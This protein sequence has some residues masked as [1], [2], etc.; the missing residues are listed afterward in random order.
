MNEQLTDTELVDLFVEAQVT[1]QGAADVCDALLMTIRNRMVEKGATQLV[2]P[3]HMVTLTIG[4]P[5]YDVG[6][7]AQLLERDD[8]PAALIDK[9]FIPTHMEPVQARW[10]GRGLNEISKL[11]GAAAEIIKDGTYRAPSMPSIKIK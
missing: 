9:A 8:V 1:R 5:S 10:D 2:H 6:V 11:G 4:K 3:T 7:L